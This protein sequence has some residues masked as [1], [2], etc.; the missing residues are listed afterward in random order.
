MQNLTSHQKDARA[1]NSVARLSIFC[2]AFL[3][4]L[5]AGAGWMTGS[6]SV[7]AS[8]LDSAMDIFASILNFI[9]VRA[10]S[11]PADEDHS[12]GHGK[13]ESLAGLFQS[14]VIG[15]SGLFLI[16]EAIHRLITPRGISSEWIG[17]ATMVV[18]VVV[19]AALV[20]RLKR[21]ARQTDSPAITSDAAHY[22]TDI[23]INEMVAEVVG[24]Y[25]DEGVLGF[26]AL[27]T[28]SSG[29]QK[30]IDLH[31][32]VEKNKRFD[33]AHDLTVKVLR[34]IEVELPRARVHIHTDPA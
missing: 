23:Y 3:I 24:R 2:A 6:V 21:V 14:I 29:S 10:S 7:L 27:R 19:S 15:F 30:F 18:S 28:R 4:L 25:K 5:K 33:E 26:H 12:Y 9:A 8:L 13:A 11:R 31:L 16:W 34:D 17:A 20:L 1:K 22:V 32:E